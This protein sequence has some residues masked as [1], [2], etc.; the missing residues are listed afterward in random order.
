MKKRIFVNLLAAL[1]LVMALA[2]A[3]LA[4]PRRSAE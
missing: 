4:L 2:P 1:L 3:G